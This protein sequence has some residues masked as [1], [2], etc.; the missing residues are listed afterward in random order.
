MADS[1]SGRAGDS[2]VAVKWQNGLCNNLFGRWFFNGWFTASFSTPVVATLFPIRSHS[3]FKFPNVTTPQ[4]FTHYS[5]NW[6]HNY[7]N[8]QV[9]TCCRSRPQ[10]L[11]SHRTGRLN[12]GKM[13]HQNPR[14]RVFVRSNAPPFTVTSQQNRSSHLL[15]SD[16]WTLPIDPRRLSRVDTGRRRSGLWAS[17]SGGR[18]ARVDTHICKCLPALHSGECPRV[19]RDLTYINSEMRS[20]QRRGILEEVGSKALL[21]RRVQYPLTYPHVATNAD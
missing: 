18:R 7:A 6:A 1:Q 10:R 2:T 12:K 21:M 17:D 15:S 11:N 8:H 19:C 20:S 14:A 5:T 4:K 9:V 13:E 16:T 3:N